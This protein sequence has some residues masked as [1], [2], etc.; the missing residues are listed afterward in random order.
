[1]NG[2]PSLQHQPEEKGIY[3]RDEIA[4]HNW[5]GDLWVIVDQDVYDLTS[6]QDEHPGGAKSASKS[7]RIVT[8]TF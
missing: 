1:M 3:S 6:F 5:T 7:D 8:H 2:S 4:Q